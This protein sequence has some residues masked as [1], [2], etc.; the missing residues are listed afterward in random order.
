MKSNL[1]DVLFILFASVLVFFMQAGF[2]MLEL[3][4]TRAKN[5]VNI[6]MKN[7]MDF[8][9]GSLVFFAIGFA[10]MF[11]TDAGGIIG[12]SGFFNPETAAQS[13]TVLPPYL[14]ILF[15]IMFC[16]TSATIVSGAMAGR[17]KFISYIVCSA[18]MSMIIYPIVGH[19][20]WGGGWL[21]NM[22]F[23]DLAGS[24]VVHMVGG[25]CAF[26]GAWQLGPRIGKYTKKGK[27]VAILGHN[28]PIAALGTFILWFGWFGFNCGS[29]LTLT[30]NVAV[31]ALNN[32]MSSSSAAVAVMIFTWII[33][34]KPD[35]SMVFNGV[36]AGLVAITAGAD[37]VTPLE[38]VIIGAVGGILMTISVELIQKAIKID[39]P[40]GAI[41]VH[42][43]C[44]LW[45]ILATGIFGK[46][47]DFFVQLVGVFAVLVYV[48]IVALIVVVIIKKTIGLRVTE[49]EEIEGLDIHEHN[50][51]AYGNFRLHDD[52]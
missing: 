9:I 43:V 22:G 20:I 18:L 46:Q 32:V 29:A 16:A 19:W 31:I 11:G 41:S 34:K 28:I 14:F 36:I 30:D 33:Y 25:I 2:A 8:A 35:A 48:F 39:D 17:T 13:H 52:R 3:G 50:S 42:G 4:F 1:I 27:P 7:I 37:I 6:V 51:I 49:Q 47:C 24:C 26:V 44:G 15:Q 23:H 5:S 38:A 21:S 40:V 12:L 10:F 45:G